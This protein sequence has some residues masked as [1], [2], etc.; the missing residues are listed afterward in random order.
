MV[1][2][3][4][5]VVC[6][7]MG[8]VSDRID[9]VQ[10]ARSAEKLDGVEFVERV[11][12]MCGDAG[13]GAAVRRLRERGCDSMLF[14]GCSPRSS[15]KFPEERI[16]RVMGGLGLS[17]DLFDVAN[18]REQCAWQH[19]DRVA[20]TLKAV[21]LVRMAHARLATAEPAP[22][23]VPLPKKALVVG[24]GPA[25]LQTAK[26]L[27][28][29]GIE[30]TLVEKKPWLGGVLCQLLRIFQ[31]E[32]W[33]SFC[34]SSCVGPAQAKG[35]ML[36][37]RVRAYTQSEVTA[38][39]RENG[40]FLVTINAAPR[41]VDPQRCISCG[42][43][44]AVCPE[45]TPRQ[46]DEGQSMRKAIDKEFERALPDVYSIVESACTKCGDCVPVCPT[47]AINLD[48]K[49]GVITDEFGVVF[50]ATGTDPMDLSGYPEY[51]RSDPDVVTA[52]EFEAIM[53][54]GFKR[55]SDG[56]VPGKVIFVQCA[57]SRAGP[58]KEVGGVQY[59]SKT[60]CSVTAKQIDRMAVANPMIEATVVYYRDMRTYERALEALYQKLRTAGVEFVN[61]EVTGI[62]A[63]GEQRLSATVRPIVSDDAEEEPEPVKIGADLIVLA[64][65]AEPAKGSADLF[66]MFGVGT[67]RYGVPIENQIRLLRPTESLVN[68]VHVVGN[69]AGSKVIQQANEQGS[70]AAMRALPSLLAGRAEPL[71]H[72][73]RVN[74][75]RCIKCRTCETVCPHGAIRMTDEGAVSDPAFCQACGFCAAACPV[76]AAE[77]TNFTDQQLLAQARVGFLGLKEGE[78]KILAL[79]CYWCSYSAADFAGVARTLA[80]VNYRAIRIR[81]SSSVNTGLVMQMFKLGVDGILVAGCPE[82]SC[83]HLWGNFVADKRTILAKSVLKQL[84]LAPARLRFEYIG[85]PMQ[86]KFV[87][88]LKEMDRDLR[89][90]GPN[91]VGLISTPGG[92]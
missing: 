84:G 24:G 43:C 39:K 59:C 45:Q 55:P 41:Y 5:V 7:C 70:A 54:N 52:L 56:E 69:S 71:R 26:D 81:C 64:A 68:R 13:L 85:A 73:S 65:A 36:S 3:I 28:A 17:K 90:L 8:Q 62:E 20:A 74:P 12:M 22:P 76:H 29:A 21:D 40:R 6:D 66:R 11:D 34:D 67:D 89:Q 23:P 18:I 63:N 50:L 2:R 1:R 46:V 60:C 92:A 16:G 14:A 57:G 15:L 30:V 79:L 32:G 4:G 86:A 72:A 82:K 33:P 53:A 48:R 44:S 9:T 35:I 58:D 75:D 80:P 49:P 87:T 37:D 78:P 19:E 25:G 61:G 42:E 47:Q 38:A 51:L 10:V 77:L 27:D 88:V 83:H 31:S 91:P